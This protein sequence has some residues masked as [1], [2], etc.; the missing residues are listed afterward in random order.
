MP[1][2]RIAK[3]LFVSALAAAFLIFAAR[4]FLASASEFSRYD[5]EG[6][7]MLMLRDYLSGKILYSGFYAQYGPFAYQALAAIHGILG[8]VP[9]NDSARI[10]SLVVYAATFSVW[11][12]IAMHLL[13]SPAVVIL[14]LLGLTQHLMTA[15]V[16][17]GHPQDLGALL[18]ALCTAALLVQRTAGSHLVKLAAAVLGGMVIAALLLTKLNV[19][20]LLIAALLFQAP[21]ARYGWRVW[22]WGI[23]LLPVVLMQQR[24]GDEWVRNFCLI[25][26]G[27]LLL[28]LAATSD[29]ADNSAP[30]VLPWISGLLAALAIILGIE[31]VRGATIRALADGIVFQH[32]DFPSLATKLGFFP[33]ETLYAAAIS[34]AVFVCLRLS[35]NQAWCKPAAD[36]CRVIAAATGLAHA[37]GFGVDYLLAFGLTFVWLLLAPARIDRGWL[38]FLGALALILPLQAYPVA[39]TQVYLGAVPLTFLC[40]LTFDE[41]VTDSK[42]S[43]IAAALVLVAGLGLLYELGALRTLA[44]RYHELTPLALPGASSVRLRPAEV[45]EYQRLTQRM[46]PFDTFVSQPGLLSLHFWTERPPPTTWNAGAWMRLIVPERQ[47]E[48]VAALQRAERPGAAVNARRAAFWTEQRQDLSSPLAAFLESSCTTVETIGEWQVRDC[49]AQR[50]G[51]RR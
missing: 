7:V 4:W 42:S 40:A 9:A 33:L 1:Q 50:P 25:E 32:L 10:S 34:V 6:F 26:T 39:G 35:R 49:A 37:I 44:G 27:G 20:V 36:A 14:F 29:R 8:L 18:V 30:P 43:L 31:V 51:E 46:K 17:P 47:R 48:I 16:E 38:T 11:A 28:F 13:R 15:T 23:L 19:G 41:V 3:F 22:R 2:S 45:E 24:L 21:L 12:G 5:D